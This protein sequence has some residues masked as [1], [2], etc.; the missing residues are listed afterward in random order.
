[1]STWLETV[2]SQRAETPR[3]DKRRTL[4][5]SRKTI[6]GPKLS[7][8]WRRQVDFT[9]GVLHPSDEQF[10]WS[11]VRSHTD[12]YIKKKGKLPQSDIDA[13]LAVLINTHDAKDI[14]I[15]A[16]AHAMSSASV[17]ALLDVQLNVAPATLY[18]VEMYLR[19]IIAANYSNPKSI[20]DIEAQWAKIILP[21]VSAHGADVAGRFLEGGCQA[22]W[23]T[24]TPSMDALPDFKI[25]LYRE[26]ETFECHLD[27]FRL[28]SQWDKAWK[29]VAWM[30]R[31]TSISPVVTQP[32]KLLPE[33]L[34]DSHFSTWRIWSTWRPNL[35]RIKLLGEIDSTKRGVLPDLLALEGP[36]FVTGQCHNLRDGLIM[37]YGSERPLLR[38][39]SLL[40]AVPSCDRKELGHLLN[41][42]ATLMDIAVTKGSKSFELFV[43]FTVARPIARENLDILEA[44]LKFP[45]TL[46]VDLENAVLEVLSARPNIGGKH[47]MDLSY[48]ILAL[49]HPNGGGLRDALL[50]PWFI[51]GI[52]KCL[53]ECQ[54][55]VRTY[56]EGDLK[57]EHLLRELHSLSS[58]LKESETIRLLLAASIRQQLD[59][60]PTAY[61][62]DL[63]LEIYNTDRAEESVAAKHRA[64][65][66]KKAIEE[67]FIDRFIEKGTVTV[68]SCKII[69][70][71][72]D[73]WT[74]TST[75][76]YRRLAILLTRLSDKDLEAQ[77][78]RLSQ[79]K[80]LSADFVESVLLILKNAE[81]HGPES[82]VQ[83]T[84]L[85]AT[86]FDTDLGKSYAAIL[87][88]LLEQHGESVI[89]YAIDNMNVLQWAQFLRKLHS[90]FKDVINDPWA[91]PPRTL[92]LDFHT[93]NQNL[94][95]TPGLMFLQ[96]LAGPLSKSAMKCILRG[97]R[98]TRTKMLLQLLV[99]LNETEEGSRS[100]FSTEIVCELAANGRNLER[101]CECV[102]ALLDT[103]QSGY[104][105]CKEIRDSS[106]CDTL[107]AEVREVVVAG[108]LEDEDTG[109]NASDKVA[110]KALAGIYGIRTYNTPVPKG[111]IMV[112]MK[113]YEGR[114]RPTGNHKKRTQR[115]GPER[116][117]SLTSTDGL[118]GRQH[119]RRRVSGPSTRHRRLCGEVF[120]KRTR[121]QLSFGHLH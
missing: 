11:S 89:D 45:A 10:P 100:Q 101:V 105:V 106:F 19:S 22:L 84:E 24:D 116:H 33:H 67:F 119:A 73:V 98:S 109:L 88:S 111:T 79:V 113:Y 14:A 59:V 104:D 65:A 62:R 78:A 103:S 52:E 44:V 115:K 76:S 39:K 63:L 83:L 48:I 28:K 96:R 121:V 66:L 37:Q 25:L 61:S 87:Y 17:R 23:S 2:T 6:F 15:A 92:Q 3:R 86:R 91:S 47:I 4:P 13:R 12:A 26:L 112:A 30:S 117:S 81:S 54:R 5:F 94:S 27:G 38:F 107:P 36:D 114:S 20:S 90:I 35:T 97:G 46:G 7:E 85:L 120:E 16:C 80:A 99:A 42:V 75:P 21:Y 49:D 69:Q 64:S 102:T 41:K 108:W 53:L 58:T 31:I 72:L 18:G 68:A 34:L 93:W 95:C 70:A 29:A 1:M 57:W 9:A 40:V 55:A 60:T 50:H 8:E 77:Y 82:C 71:V 56:I 43:Q 32:G 51:A 118:S 110:I 74:Q